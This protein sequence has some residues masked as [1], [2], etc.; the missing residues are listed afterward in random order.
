M[1]FSVNSFFIIKRDKWVEV[2]ACSQII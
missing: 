2:A 1:V